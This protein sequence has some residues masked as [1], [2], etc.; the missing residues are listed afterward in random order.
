MILDKSA[1]G[2]IS[3]LAHLISALK[4]GYYHEV[5]TQSD[6]LVLSVEEL[7]PY[8][9]WN[10][11]RYTR[12]CIARDDYFEL[13]LLCWE[14]GQRTP[15]H[16]HDEQ[17]CWVKV[18]QGDFAESFYAYEPLT[19]SMKY[20]GTDIVAQHEVTSIEDQA[21]YHSLEN[22]NRGRSMSLHLYM[23][24]IAECLVYNKSNQKLELRSLQYDTCHS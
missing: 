16:N 22:I 10:D 21:L 8:I 11:K 20:V 9:S 17:E 13:I 4:Y 24:P 2:K 15:I 3:S 14:K 19:D 23:K 7:Q 1:I 6:D 12:N 18:I 5:L